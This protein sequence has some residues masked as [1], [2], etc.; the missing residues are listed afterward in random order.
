MKNISKFSVYIFSFFVIILFFSSCKDILYSEQGIQITEDKLFDDWYEYRSVSM[1]LYGLQ[2]MLVGQI[3][4]LGELRGD[5]LTITDNADADLIELYNFN[6]SRNNEYA[7]P[8]NFFKLISACNSFIRILQQNHP[9]VLDFDGPVSNYDRLYGEVLCMRAWAYFNAARIYGKVPFVN[10]SLTSIDEIESFLNSSDTYIIDVDINF[11][12]GG[13][14]NDTIYNKPV[15]LEKQFYSLDLIIDY[16]TN[17]L[18]TKVKAVGV[19]HYIDNNDNSWEVTVWNTHAMHTLLGIMYLTAG[20]LSMAAKYFEKIVYLP[21]DN[22]RYQLDNSFSLTNWRNIFNTV[23]RREHIYTLSFNKGNLQQNE[24]QAF[25]ESRHPHQYML[26]P[27][28]EAILKWETIWDNYSLIENT[29]NPSK[30]I[31]NPNQ[32]GMPG[33]FHRGYGVSYAYLRNGELIDRE[34]ISQMLSLK[35]D[36]DFFSAD[37]ITEGADTVVWKYSWNKNI[38]DKDA[39]FIIY[40]AAGVHLW[41]AEV[42]TYWVFDRNGIIGTFTSNAVNII[43]DGS[44]YGSSVSRSQLG[45]RGR[46]GFGGTHDGI[47]VEN[48]IYERDPFSN[49]VIGYLDYTGSLSKKQMYMEE[50]ILDERARELAFEGERFYDLMRIAK[51]RNDPSF[52]AEKVSKKYPEGR[53]EEIY[54][55]LLDENNWYINYFE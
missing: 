46:V 29:S 33:D 35:A 14:Y 20:D 16:F 12:I 18:E 30:T 3:V 13:F 4:I 6:V 55:L 31:L 39:N 22:N 24:L 49:E 38:F 42:Y 2:Q 7:S 44:N 37:F 21:S 45:V 52:L 17:E 11:S 41:L 48:I 32:K 9:E 23:D 26:K 25:F 47:R 50:Q 27:T 36:N 43:N 19:N 1:G 51:R 53:R 10:D 34:A 15:N 40:R 28:R 5:L 54:N 8:A